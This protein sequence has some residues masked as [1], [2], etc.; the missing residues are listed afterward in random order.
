[1]MKLSLMKQFFDSVDENWRSPIA[2][3]IAA[4]WMSRNFSAYC[5]RASANFAFQVNAGDQKFLLRFNHASE[6]E[7]EFIAGELAFIEHLAERGIRVARSQRSL[8]GNMIES[9]M[10]PMGLFHAVLFEFLP[11][12]CLELEI[13]DP[14]FIEH[15]GRALGEMHLASEGLKVDGRLDWSSQLDCVRQWVPQSETAVWRE[16]DAIEEKLHALPRCESNYGLVHFDFELDNLVWSDNEVG[17]FDL[18]DCAYEWFAMDISN[19]PMR[20]LFDDRMERVDLADPR[21]QSFLKGYRS[22]RQMDEEE[23][24]W[25]PL[26]LRLDNLFGFARDYRSIAEGPVENEP[27]W[28]TDLRLK[29]SSI[30]DKYRESFR[31]HPIGE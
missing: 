16:V 26:F 17:I 15:W 10:T 6:R 12:K 21:L 29:L 30:L 23:M 19:G 3:Q 4:Q 7:P 13:L 28:T 1:M 27:Q 24:H 9:V 18:D 2:D 31:I 14:P 5:I 25:L 11:G 8:S 20:E 22:V